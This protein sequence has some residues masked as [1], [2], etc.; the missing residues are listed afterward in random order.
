MRIAIVVSTFPKL[1]E[2]FILNQITGLLELGHEVEIFARRR[3]TKE[4]KVH[5]DVERYG[6][7]KKVNYWPVP[8]RWLKRA[9]TGLSMLLSGLGSDP[10]S[11][12]KSLNFFKFG[13]KALSLKILYLLVP[14]IGKRFDITHCHFADIGAIG[15]YLKDLGF[16]GKF[17]TT[18]HGYDVNST[19]HTSGKGIYRHLFRTCDLFTAN[20]HFTKKQAVSLGCDD[21][22]ITVLPMG[23]RTE[24]FK[25]RIRLLKPGETVKLLTVGRLVEKKGHR[26]AIEALERVVRKHNNLLYRIAGNGPLRDELEGLVKGLGLESHVKFLGDMSEDEIQ[27]LY[28]DSHIFVLPSVTSHVEDRE[29]QALVLQEAQATGMP[30]VSTY[31]N[32]IPEGVLNCKSGYLVPEKKAD[33]LREKIEFLIEHPEMWPEMGWHGRRFIERKYDLANLNKRLEDIYASLLKK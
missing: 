3:N 26:Y 11:A 25:F 20:T 18:F 21:K 28:H 14:F 24:R 27:A 13:R 12:L 23:L 9:V 10:V 32:G 31:H 17:I 22:K 1:S 19:P 15:V 4:A 7:M 29:G 2:S 6:L 5:P 33:A 30:V 8:D 16:P